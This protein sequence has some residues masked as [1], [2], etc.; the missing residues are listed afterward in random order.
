MSRTISK[1]NLS[2][3]DKLR[4][5][6]SCA[7]IIRPNHVYLPGGKRVKPKEK[8]VEVF[9]ECDHSYVVPIQATKWLGYYKFR[10]ELVP[11]DGYTLN[12]IVLKNYQEDAIKLC[13]AR[14]GAYNSLLI[15]FPPGFGKTIT[16]ISLW[17]YIRNKLVILINRSTLLESWKNTITLCFGT[18][19]NIR[20]WVVG[21]ESK[22]EG[23]DHDADII[24]CM[25]QRVKKIPEEVRRNIGTLVVDEAHLFCTPSHIGPMLAFSP[26]FVLFATAT[27]V[28]EDGSSR[29]I[30][31][32][33]DKK[34]WLSYVSRRPYIVHA[35]LTGFNLQEL[36]RDEGLSTTFQSKYKSA[37]KHDPR[38]TLIRHLVKTARSQEK[39]CMVL[40]TTHEH[41]KTMVEK[42][43]DLDNCNLA[44]YYG[45]IKGCDNYNV[46]VGT[47]PKM[48]TGYDEATACRQF[49]G[50]K[51]NVLILCTSVKSTNLF[52]QLIG[53]I[54]RGDAPH[55]VWL[56][57]DDR[58]PHNH[59]YEMTQFIKSTNGHIRKHDLDDIYLDGIDFSEKVEYDGAPYELAP[60][61]V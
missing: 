28:K 52:E 61:D 8:R 11:R 13:L 45:T 53:R 7:F 23:P 6:K 14:L 15:R 22:K 54:M 37:H 38:N 60:G 35:I 41:A 56:I 29:I 2:K 10:D 27:P 46:V 44:E 25:A 19:S 17:R 58:N 40:T 5:E 34:S 39:K 1:E 49:D 48:G 43:S 26:N 4:I 55:L 21:E 9:E 33:V 59:L 42:L 12:Q 18:G 57:D 36:C 51:S 50:I 31:Y 47:I 30:D 3:E 16:A 24:I 32:F 20:V